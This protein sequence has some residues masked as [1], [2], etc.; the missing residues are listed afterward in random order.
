MARSV[1]VG[2]KIPKWLRL[3]VRPRTLPLSWKIL[4]VL[5]A[6]SPMVIF[7]SPALRVLPSGRFKV[8]LAVSRLRGPLPKHFQ[9][10]RLMVPLLKSWVSPRV[11]SFSSFE[12]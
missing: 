11:S 5:G 12:V 7:F 4:T 6:C 9:N 8:L 3:M 10:S 2:A 1:P